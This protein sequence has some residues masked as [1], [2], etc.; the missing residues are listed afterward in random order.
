MPIEG[1]QA[2]R[3]RAQLLRVEAV[4]WS[5]NFLKQ[6]N[7]IRDRLDVDREAWNDR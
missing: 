5:F 6:N 4:Q 3:R 7:I 2:R 1:E